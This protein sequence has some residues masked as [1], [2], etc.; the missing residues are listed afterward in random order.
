MCC[1]CYKLVKGTADDSHCKIHA[2]NPDNGALQMVQALRNEDYNGRILLEVP[3][4]SHIPAG[5]RQGRVK[6]SKR[7]GQL[8]AGPD[9]RCDIV[10]EKY[11]GAIHA[12]V[13]AGMKF[14]DVV[15]V[16]LD[17]SEHRYR[18]KTKRRDTSKKKTA[19]FTVLS[20][21]HDRGKVPPSG[22]MFWQGEAEKVLSKWQ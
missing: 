7:G 16:E 14:D 12:E 10:L 20:V 22:D 5:K 17:G 18:K 21:Q 4:W 3:G 6:S 9:M 11:E 1:G 13:R 19:P 15:A 2:G 8:K